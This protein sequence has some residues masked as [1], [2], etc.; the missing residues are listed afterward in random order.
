[1]LVRMFQFRVRKGREAAT[2]TFMRRVALKVLKKVKGCLCAYFTRGAGK[3]EYL[4]VTV[5]TNERALKKGIARR[6]W[7]A[8]LSEETKSFFAGRPTVKHYP[9]LAAK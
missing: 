1:M 2:R 9:V 6:D 8:L 7:Q 3:G 4:W 5:W